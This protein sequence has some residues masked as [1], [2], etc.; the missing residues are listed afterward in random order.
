MSVREPVTWLAELTSG[1][2]PSIRER[3]SLEG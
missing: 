3:H 1:E 2:E